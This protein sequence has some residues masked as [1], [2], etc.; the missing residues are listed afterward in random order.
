MRILVTNNSFDLRSGTELFC[1]DIALELT[2]RGHQVALYSSR[3]GSS[4]QD[5]RQLGL[6][7]IS[8]LTDL[9]FVPQIIHGQHHLDAMTALLRFP[10]TP[11]LLACHGASD[12]L[13]Q[14]INFPS[15]QRYIA[16]DDPTHERLTSSGVA[17]SSIEIL[18]TAVDLQRF[19]QRDNWSPHPQR[20]LFFSNYLWD[21][22]RFRIFREACRLEGIKTFDVIGSGMGAEKTNPEKILSTYDIVFAKGRSAHE[23]VATGAGVILTDCQKISGMLTTK[24]YDAWRPLNLGFKTLTQTA[25]LST[26]RKAIKQYDVKD[27]KAV[28]HRLRI[29]APLDRAIDRLEEIYESVISEGH[30]TIPQ[31]PETAFQTAASTYLTM[32]AAHI[33]QHKLTVPAER[34]I[35]GIIRKT[36]A[37]LRQFFSRR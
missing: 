4:G 1:R 31:I 7:V 37:E 35:W 30:K 26:I 22:S 10:R 13:E 14:P 11:A 27:I 24:K 8:D 33:K 20:A 9:E 15:I 12:W 25:N 23:A 32:V 2:R 21:E 3:N 5:F 29:D 6:R 36:Y 17:N 16:V 28:S 19:P 18:R 34:F